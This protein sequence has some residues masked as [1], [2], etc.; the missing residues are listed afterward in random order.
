M[1]FNLLCHTPLGKMQLVTTEKGLLFTCKLGQVKGWVKL[2]QSRDDTGRK[3]SQR[4]PF[5]WTLQHQSRLGESCEEQEENSVPLNPHVVTFAVL[6]SHY[7][8]IRLRE[9][10]PWRTKWRAKWICLQ[11]PTVPILCKCFCH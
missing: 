11:T 5:N 4:H 9:K 3:E 2:S 8:V 7:Q 6:E 1:H 10:L